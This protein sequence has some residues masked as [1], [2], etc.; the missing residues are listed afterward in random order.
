ML[1]L[2]MGDDENPHKLPTSICV[3]VMFV[4]LLLVLYMNACLFFRQFL[5][6]YVNFFIYYFLSN[7]KS[8]MKLV[9]FS[10]PV[11][12]C[13]LTVILILFSIVL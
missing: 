1:L 8:F 2:H 4:L 7:L 9:I 10:W 3:S 11:S 5:K 12:M 13:L 6:L